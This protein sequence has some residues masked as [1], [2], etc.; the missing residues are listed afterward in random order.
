MK[1]FKTKVIDSLELPQ[2]NIH[3]LIYMSGN[4]SIGEGTTIGLF[5]E[6]NANKSKVA[7][8]K[9]CDIASFVSINCADSHKLTLGLSDEIQRREIILEDNVFVGS[10]SFIGGYVKIG[11]HSVVAAG[12]VLINL[13]EIPPYSLIAGNPATVKERYYEI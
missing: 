7:I 9:N 3:P 2:N 6:V 8:G 10:H 5:S 1:E 13:G 12:A 11:H 4:Y